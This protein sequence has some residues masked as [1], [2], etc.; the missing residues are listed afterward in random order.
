M[1][2]HTD[3]SWKNARIREAEAALDAAT[4]RAD[5]LV[6]E[7]RELRLPEHQPT[8]TADVA[9]QL[10][11]AARRPDAPPELRAMARKVETGAFT[12]QDVVEGRAAHDPD[13]QR[14]QEANM[15]RLRRSFQ[16]LQEGHSPDEVL[17]AEQ[18]NERGHRDD[19]DE[20]G[21]LRSS[22]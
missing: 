13:V 6:R 9:R 2:D 3:Q 7:L 1:P 11:E 16:L 8:D 20:G 5:E 19:D 21:F 14:A 10:E 4:A 17:E 18:Y 22:W 15:A 12:W